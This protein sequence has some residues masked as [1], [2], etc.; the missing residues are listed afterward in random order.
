MPPVPPSV[1]PPTA[2]DA[3]ALSTDGLVL[4]TERLV[5]RRMTADDAPFILE[6]LNEPSF[7]EFIGDKK[8]RTVEDAAAYIEN[9]P[10]AMYARVGHGMWLALRKEDGAPIGMCGL[11]KRD[12]LPDV[13]VGYALVPRFWGM[14]YANEAVAATL[15]YGR[16]TMGMGRIVAITS[17][18]NDASRRVLERCGFRLEGTIVQGEEE[19]NLFASDA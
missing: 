18:H 5:L 12:T 13:D 11:I 4:E 1:S 9:G 15:A 6:L 14:G 2:P 19:L 17:L 16:G 8:V 10:V 7:L 3:A